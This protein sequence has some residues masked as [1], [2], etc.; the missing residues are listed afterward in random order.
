MQQVSENHA[1]TSN[2]LI[3]AFMQTIQEAVVI[4][5]HKLELIL[6]TM[7]ARGHVLLEDIPRYW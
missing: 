1:T 2:T 4:E 5:D 6:A 3:K 7:L